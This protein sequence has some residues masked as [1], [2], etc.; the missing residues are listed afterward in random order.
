MKKLLTLCVIH[1]SP[2]VLLAMK[3]RGFGTGKWNGYG[4]KVKED[5]S[6]LDAT[7]RELQEESG[8]IGND[9]ELLG[10]LTFQFKDNL[11]EL[12]EMHIFRLNSFQG[13]PQETEEMR[14][15]WF[16]QGDI[17]YNEMW[18]ADQLWLPSFLEGKKFTGHFLYESHG[19]DIILEHKINF[20]DNLI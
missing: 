11:D 8:I 20:T 13:E 1:Q 19:S 2:R 4:G 14:P 6:I 5:E 17:P 15:Q 3:K 10:I 9:F 7:K 18:C 16:S 12:L